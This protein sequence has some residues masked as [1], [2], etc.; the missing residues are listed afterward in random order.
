[1]Y[2]KTVK[3]HNPKA[4]LLQ[5][6]GFVSEKWGLTTEDGVEVHIA[7]DE[8]TIIL[9]PRKGLVKV[10]A[11]GRSNEEGKRLVEYST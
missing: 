8:R 3:V 9:K 10:L 6:P 4:V 7:D 11:G 5:I 1:M 2:L